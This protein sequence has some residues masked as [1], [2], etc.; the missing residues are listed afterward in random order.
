[1]DGNL[2]KSNI[3]HH[4]WE[5]LSPPIGTT[6]KLQPMVKD[7]VTSKPEAATGYCRWLE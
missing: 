2:S 3:C 5:G 1:M 6:A 4:N 7:V